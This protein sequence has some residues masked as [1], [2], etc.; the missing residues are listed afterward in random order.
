MQIAALALFL[1]GAVPIGMALF[2]QVRQSRTFTKEM[3][4]RRV[5]SVPM[6]QNCNKNW[7]GR[8]APS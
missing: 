8:S 3:P 5:R 6:I 4:P 7:A 2:I 1:L